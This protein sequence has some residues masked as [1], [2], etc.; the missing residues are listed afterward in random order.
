MSMLRPSALFLSVLVLC[1]WDGAV[2]SSPQHLEVCSILAPMAD[3]NMSNMTSNHTENT[4]MPDIIYYQVMRPNKTDC[5]HY[6][7]SAQMFPTLFISHTE[8]QCAPKNHCNISYNL[9]EFSQSQSYGSV[10]IPGKDGDFAMAIIFHRLIEFNVTK[11]HEASDVFNPSQ[12]SN[13]SNPEYE[14]TYLNQSELEWSSNIDGKSL[15]AKSLEIN[16]TLQFTIRYNLPSTTDDARLPYFPG[17]V[18]TE[19]STT[20]DLEIQNFFYRLSTSKKPSSRLALELLLVHGPD[21]SNGSVSVTRTIDD[22]H[23][24]SVFQTFQYLFGD[25]HIGYLQWKPISYQNSD[26]AST[27]SQQAN[28]VFADGSTIDPLPP[29]LASALFNSSTVNV[30]RM[31]MVFGSSGDDSY[32]NSDYMTW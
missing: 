24:P 23:T 11:K 25:S 6:A 12:A 15:M 9:E 17:T 10:D 1:C 18:F 27:S 14:S 13:A 26:R 3:L 7:W 8:G 29:S 2:E 16:S 30:T 22:E 4:Y 20:F 28:V 21:T 19:N 31:F 5:M 32:L